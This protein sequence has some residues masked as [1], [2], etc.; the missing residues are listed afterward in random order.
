[1]QLEGPEDA[2][3]GDEVTEE[4]G[5]YVEEGEEEEVEEGEEEEEEEGSSSEEDDRREFGIYQC[6]PVEAGEPRWEEGEPQT[7]EE[8][9]RRVRYEA[10][11]L[12]DVSAA[13][14]PPPA[15]AAHRQQHAADAPHSQ[16]QDAER[17]RQERVQCREHYSSAYLAADPGVAPCHPSLKPSA[18]WTRDFLHQFAQLRRRLQREYELSS[19][20]A[21][22][23]LAGGDGGPDA[24]VQAELAA[25]SLDPPSACM[26]EL[27]Q[28]QG[29][30]QLQVR[31]QLHSAM[32]EA[33]RCERLAPEA[34]AHLY[35]L[36]ARIEKPLHAGTC[37]LYRQLLRLCAQQRAALCVDAA[38]AD[39]LLPHLNILITLAGAFFGQDE[40]L[41]AMW[42]E[43]EE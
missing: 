35:A 22:A 3:M 18:A 6:L 10:R 16:R 23:G 24:A 28:L 4:E 34:A 19:A 41:A 13:P 15:A 40:E 33:V 11:Q 9:L 5:V 29:L 25:L 36:S 21:A 7:V 43:D 8:Y 39:P 17:Q 42:E 32:R 30:D 38:P 1:M 2:E 37:A 20:Q 27:Q 12:P 31:R 26:P 14:P